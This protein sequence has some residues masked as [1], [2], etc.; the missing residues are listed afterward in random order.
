MERRRGDGETSPIYFSSALSP[1]H[2]VDGLSHIWP[3]SGATAPKWPVRSQTFPGIDVN[4]AFL[5]VM[6]SSVFE[7]F[8]LTTMCSQTMC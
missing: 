7:S 5:Q 8:S 2:E 4:L 1:P 6:F 3:L